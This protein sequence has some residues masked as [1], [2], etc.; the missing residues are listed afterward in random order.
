MR[1]IFSKFVC[2]SE[3]PNFTTV[4]TTKYNPSDVILPILDKKCPTFKRHGFLAQFPMNVF[5]SSD[6]NFLSTGGA[7]HLAKNAELPIPEF[8]HYFSPGL[9]IHTTA[10]LQSVNWLTYLVSRQVQYQSHDDLMKRKK[11]QF[12]VIKCFCFM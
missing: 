3:S 7:H 2:F 1:K 6:E 11:N 8:G 5:I 4:F 10:R 9:F 12:L